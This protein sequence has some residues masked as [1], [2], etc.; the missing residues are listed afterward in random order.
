M[1][2]QYYHLTPPVHV[3]FANDVSMLECAFELFM[4]IMIEVKEKR[5]V[6]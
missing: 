4:E 5:F 2:T 6:I 3:N 1:L